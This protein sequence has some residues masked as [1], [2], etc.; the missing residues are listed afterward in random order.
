VQWWQHDFFPVASRLGW[1]TLVG[2]LLFLQSV[3]VRP[4]GSD[5]PL[6]S[7][8]FEFW[9]YALFP[10]AWLALA[11]SISRM[12]RLALGAVF[13]ALLCVVG[14]SIAL[15]F[16]IWLF[17]AIVARMP[18]VPMLRSRRRTAISVASMCFLL[19]LALSH[20]SRFRDLV[21]RSVVAADYLNGAACA[22]LVYVL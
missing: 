14:R 20:A 12:K 18:E 17:G 13:V 6:W 8:S 22:L 3:V 10:C 19:I 2:N 16:P 21:D 5:D 1:E 11:S 15:Y 7:L 9:Y 4:F